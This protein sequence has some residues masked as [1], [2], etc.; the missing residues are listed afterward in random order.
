MSCVDRIVSQKKA[1]IGAPKTQKQI[2]FKEL[3]WT[4]DE[5]IKFLEGLKLYGMNAKLIAEYIGT[6]TV[7]QVSNH[8]YVM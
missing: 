2:E 7:K 5:K 6:R 8:R 3:V 1:S 4:P